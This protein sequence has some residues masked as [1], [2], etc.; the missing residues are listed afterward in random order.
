MVV[1][2]L[3]VGVWRVFVRRQPFFPRRRH[4]H[5]GH[6]HHKSAQK[7]V[8]VAEEKSGLMDHQDPAPSY[9]EEGKEADV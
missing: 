7:E 9:E 5:T 1:G 6:V 3:I 8:A 4:H 2:T